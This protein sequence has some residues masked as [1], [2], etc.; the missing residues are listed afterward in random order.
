MRIAFR[1][2]LTIAA[3]LVYQTVF[4]AQ[5][6]KPSIGLSSLPMPADSICEIPLY[7]DPDGSF[8]TTGLQAGDTINH[9]KL[10]NVNNQETDIA[11]ELQKGKPILL[12]AGSYTCPVFRGKVPD[13]DAIAQKYGNQL[14]IFI[15]YVL[16][17]HPDIDTSPYSGNVWTTSSNINEGILY[18]QPVTYGDRVSIVQDMLNNMSISYEV[19]IDGPCNRWWN[20]FGPA[21]NN[22]YLIEPNGVIFAKHGWF[23]KL[24]FDM[25]ADI[26]SLL[27]ISAISEQIL[28]N[29]LSVYPNPANSTVNF[30]FKTAFMGELQLFNSIGEMVKQT[31]L[32]MQTNYS[33]NVEGLDR[34][35]YYYQLSGYSNKISQGKLI[36]N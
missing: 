7:L 13:I 26:D 16:E 4:F 8:K 20:T 15:I 11:F 35:I 22:A 1:I 30:N 34:G 25:S 31:Q 3:L 10:Y 21:P 27:G 19:L 24:P 17:P 9:F 2:I 32:N 29:S 28:N 18:R 6:L 12:V 5:S 36:V 33:L 23:N 14:S